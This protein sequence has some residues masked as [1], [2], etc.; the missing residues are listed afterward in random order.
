M[1][2]IFFA[3]ARFWWLPFAEAF[4]PSRPPSKPLN[5]DEPGE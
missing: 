4:M 5:R 2:P 3:L 1:N